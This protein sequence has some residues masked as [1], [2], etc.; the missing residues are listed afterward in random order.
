MLGILWSR[1]VSNL[2][3]AAVDLVVDNCNDIGIGGV[4]VD[5]IIGANVLPM[6]ATLGSQLL[7]SS[8][9]MGNVKM[10]RTDRDFIIAAT[11]LVLDGKQFLPVRGH[12]INLPVA[13]QGYVAGKYEVAMINKDAPWRWADPFNKLVRIHTRFVE[14]K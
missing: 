1:P 11:Y 10:E 5:Y 6:I 4:N 8:D 9:G 2:F 7:K 3:E 12:V 13:F 14:F